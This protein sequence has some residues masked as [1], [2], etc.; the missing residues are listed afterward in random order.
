MRNGQSL[1]LNWKFKDEF[2]PEYITQKD[3]GSFADIHVPHTVRE[4]PYDCFDETM[5]GCLSTYVRFFEL[6]A[7]GEQRVL[8]E[9]EGVSTY[10]D[11]YVNEQK[12]GSHKG[13]YSIA[14]FDITSFV[15]EGENKLML[16]VDS[17]VRTDIP[18]EGAT[19]D[20]LL[21]GGI[22][23]DVTLYI[24]EPAYVIQNLFRYTLEGS[25]AWAAPELMVRNHGGAFE[26]EVL[27][28]LS[29]DRE[30]VHSYR[31][32]VKV[33]EGMCRIHL[34]KEALHGVERW[35]LDTPVLYDVRVTLSREGKVLDEHH[36]RVGFRTT[37]VDARGF[38]L[39]GRKVKLIGLN[40]HQSYPY[41]GYAMGKRPQ[42][43][44]ADILKT[45]LGLNT[46][47]CSHYMQSKYFL[48]RC[49]E[50]GLMVFEEI[51]GWGYLGGEDYK[52]VSR[53][54]LRNMVLGHFNHPSIIIWGTRL[55]ESDDDD[56]FYEGTNR[57]CKEMDPTRPTSG[58]R[59]HKNSPLLEDIYSYNDYTPP[60]PR[61][62][63]RGEFMI[64]EQQ[65]VSGLPYKAPYLISEHTAPLNCTKPGDSAMRHERFALYHAR[66]VDKVL[67]SDDYLGAL[68]WCM[69]DYNTHHDHSR[70]EKICYH[71]V[72][73]MFRVPKWASYFYRSQK[74]PSEEVVLQP[75]SVIGRGERSE[76]VTP[77]YVLTNCDYIDV[78]LSGDE[79]RRFYPSS[80]FPGLKHAPIEVSES[81]V[82]W[83]VFWEGSTIVGYVDQKEAARITCTKNPY[84]KELDLRADDAELYCDRVDETRLV[85]TFR[86]TDGLRMLHHF[87]IG[88]ITVE[89]DIELIGPDTVPVLGGTI[90]FWIRTKALG[91][92]GEAK[93][94]V[95]ACRPGLSDR[96]VTIRLI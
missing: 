33:G 62:P 45:E 39:N 73:D 84:L 20:Y 55:N 85:C 48:D 93:V 4:I 23:R 50:L 3:Y 95:S 9:F 12:A 94:T 77:F 80:R 70:Q 28:E 10:Y 91:R 65:A 88:K 6:P 52:E 25:Q 76:E 21:Y 56:A 49:D 41:V 53:S 79:T 2:K 82:F 32:P 60:C 86:D 47:R 83:Q 59:W 87:G 57:L 26:G 38:Y 1:N 5:C 61:E 18:P 89:G 14:L 90:A 75:C 30:Q 7:L 24:L 58:V 54:D 11:L 51:P 67:T 81:D 29:R 16:M 22:Y 69:F 44:D 34:E 46:V 36:T 31:R 72:L 66:V 37:E 42:Q 40:R 15:H 78:T 63:G 68:G 96:T 43:K 64:K 71:G 27:V 8:I 35:D 13:A 17:N 74:D 19:V 92:K